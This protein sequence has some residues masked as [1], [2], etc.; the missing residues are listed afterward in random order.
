MNYKMKITLEN[1][2][3]AEYDLKSPLELVL[4]CKFS[5]N[6]DTYGNGHYVSIQ[7]KNFSKLIFDIRY[8]KNFNRNNK[9]EWL[10][11]WAKNY[12]SGENGSW[13]LTKIEI[14]KIE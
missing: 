8:D 7:G 3:A 13:K 5:Y 12:W 11:K 14:I 10:E 6:S 9:T 1:P 2:N 4:E